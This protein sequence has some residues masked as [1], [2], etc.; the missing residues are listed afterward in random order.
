MPARP[1]THAARW[2]STRRSC[3]RSRHAIRARPP[4]RWRHTST[5]HWAS[6]VR[7]SQSTEEGPGET[8]PIHDAYASA[9]A[10]AGVRSGGPMKVLFLGQVNNL[11]PWFRDVVTA[12][13]EEHEVVLWDADAPLGPQIQDAQVVVDQGGGVGSQ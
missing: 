3:R 7:S 2:P 8:R 4:K 10:A 11:E 5:A 1:A 6:S 9:R 12:V 13:G